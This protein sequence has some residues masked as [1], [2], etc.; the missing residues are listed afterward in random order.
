M[1]RFLPTLDPYVDYVLSR[2]LDSPMTQRETDTIDIWMSDEQKHKFFYIARDNAEHNV[3]IMGGLWGSAN[4]RA[5]DY[6]FDVFQPMLMPSIG[7]RYRGRGDQW[8]L[9]DYVWAKVRDHSLAFDSFFCAK[10]GGRPFP[11]QR[12]KGLCYLGCIRPC[13]IN[14]TDN[15]SSKYMKPCPVGCRPK[16][17]QDWKFC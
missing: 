6:L 13:C 3:Q 5:R 16:D 11:S 14:S 9:V 8:F 1:W 12:P 2:D 10:Y 4:V 15:D 17:H 7:N